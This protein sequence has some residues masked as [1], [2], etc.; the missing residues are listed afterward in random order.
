MLLSRTMAR[1]SIVDRNLSYADAVRGRVS[2]PQ[3][4]SS[5]GWRCKHC[6]S[7]DVYVAILAE[8]KESLLGIH[9]QQN[10]V[11]RG[12]S[13]WSVSPVEVENRASSPT[14][15]SAKISRGW[16]QLLVVSNSRC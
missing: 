10:G 5:R 15:K 12:H 14:R 13:R 8:E 7:W 3:S 9:N 4:S 11:E 1:K 6:G 16:I 2:D